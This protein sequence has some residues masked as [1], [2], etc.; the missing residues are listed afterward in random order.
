MSNFIYFKY[1]H[2]AKLQKWLEEEDYKALEEF[3]SLTEFI[4]TFL[5]NKTNRWMVKS[6]IA[7]IKREAYNQY[8]SILD[9]EEDVFDEKWLEAIE[10]YCI[11]ISLL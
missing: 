1:Y 9:L 2:Q 5:K 8:S 3:N 6:Y 7:S 11:A 4:P 10:N